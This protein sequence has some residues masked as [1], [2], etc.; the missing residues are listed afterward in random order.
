MPKGGDPVFIQAL[1]VG[2]AET[3]RLPLE[4]ADIQAG[5]PELFQ[6]TA[7]R[8]Q[9]PVHDLRWTLVAISLARWPRGVVG[10]G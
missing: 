10:N 5:R 1:E 8:Q 2:L 4:R 9:I 7:S 3:S 6:T